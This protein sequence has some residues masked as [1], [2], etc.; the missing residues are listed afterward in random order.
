MGELIMGKA[1]KKQTLHSW[2]QPSQFDVDD[3]SATNASSVSGPSEYECLHS[4][5]KQH[6]QITYKWKL[7]HPSNNTA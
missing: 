3:P 4:K 1:D 7:Q 2:P 5:V 6:M